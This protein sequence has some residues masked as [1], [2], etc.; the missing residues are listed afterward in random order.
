MNNIVILGC[1]LSGMITALALAKHKIQSHIIEAKSATDPDFFDDIRTTALNSSSTDFFQKI[2]IWHALSSECGPI[3]DIYVADNKAPEMLH[4]SSEFTPNNE[5]MGYL[6]EN[7]VFKKCLYDLVKANEFITVLDG[8]KY[9]EV[10]NKEDACEIISDKSTIICKLLIACDG[11][12]SKA[13]NLF[14]SNEIDKNYEQKAITFI[15]N[16][17]KN[18]ENT[19]VEH[20]M[21]TGPF[22]ILPLKDGNKSSVVW[23]LHKDHA[24]V[25]MELPIDEFTHLVQFNFGQFLGKIEIVSKIA[26]FPLKAHAVKKYYNKNIVLVADTAHIIHPLAGQGLNQ[27]IKDIECLSDLIFEQGVNAKTL[28][29]YQKIRQA[30][31]ENMLLI[32]DTINN[33]FSS[34]S[35]IF[36]ACRQIGFKATEIMTPL[37][38]ILIKYAIG[39]R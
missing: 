30:D 21:Q 9:K 23:T 2:D 27:G 39:K 32:T 34:K 25:L 35:Q 4:F 5:I 24:S 28:A 8:I 10:K 18:H 6:I 15:V 16:H 36:H 38:K 31:N 11:R 19:A 13:K 3:N 12:N 14:F 26:A 7:S 20:F 29:D 1:G 37:K 17:E 33:I 22:A